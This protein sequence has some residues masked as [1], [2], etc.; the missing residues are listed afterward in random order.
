MTWLV[1][2]TDAGRVARNQAEC[3]A[4]LE[5]AMPGAWHEAAAVPGGDRDGDL[6]RWFAGE[7]GWSYIGVEV[8]GVRLA[9]WSSGVEEAAHLE[10]ACPTTAER[11]RDVLAA[12]VERTY[13]P[14]DW[15]APVEVIPLPDEH[16]G[17]LPAVDEETRRRVRRWTRGGL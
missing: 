11:L 15:F 2:D 12:P 14:I 1:F 9:G 7:R 13:T 17:K 4:E 6:A 5:A 8:A 3:L 10:R 16:P